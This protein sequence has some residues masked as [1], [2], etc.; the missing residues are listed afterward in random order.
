VTLKR[1]ATGDQRSVPRAEVVAHI[2]AA[3]NP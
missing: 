2:R 3:L 1:L